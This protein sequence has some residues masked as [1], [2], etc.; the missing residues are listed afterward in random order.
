MAFAFSCFSCSVRDCGAR[1]GWWRTSLLG[2]GR[3]YLQHGFILYCN[4]RQDFLKKA[5]ILDL[6]EVT[7]LGSGACRL[8]PLLLQEDIKIP[9]HVSIFA[10]SKELK[11]LKLAGSIANRERD[12]FRDTALEFDG[13][14]E[15]LPYCLRKVGSK[16]V[17]PAE[18]FGDFLCESAQLLL[19]LLGETK[20]RR[21]KRDGWNQGAWEWVFW[22]PSDRAS[23]R[24]K[25]E[26]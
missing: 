8:L 26:D 18:C 1:W 17:A 23:K 14:E 4:A 21:I 5:G 16:Y 10:E 12:R 6:G 25:V 2:I 7:V 3:F 11:H 13:N 24:R 15:N 19:L 22:K 9:G 20:N